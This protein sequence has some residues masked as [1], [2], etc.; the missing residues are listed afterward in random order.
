MKSKKS[1]EELQFELESINQ[2]RK[3]ISKL[4]K[5]ARKEEEIAAA[6]VAKEE[7]IR[8]AIGLLNWARTVKYPD[9]HSLVEEY[10]N[11]QARDEVQ[12][13]IE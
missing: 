11:C 9:G 8:L 2:K 13:G 6:K 3:E 1:L 5:L 7:E 10:E 12:N 4:L